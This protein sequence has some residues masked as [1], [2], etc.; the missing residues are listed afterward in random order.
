MPVTFSN[1]NGTTGSFTLTNNNN[2]G[3]LNMSFST[4]RPVPYSYG[5]TQ[6][7]FDFSN[8]GSYSNS[9]T[10]IAD[11][12]GNG[13][14]GIFTFGTGNG[15]ATTVTGYNTNGY[16]TLPGDSTSQLA[17]RLPNALKP[18]TR[19]I[20]TYIVY[21][22][23][24]GYESLSTS[25][26]GIISNDAGGLGLAWGISAV[27][28]GSF[29]TRNDLGFTQVTYSGGAGLNVWSVYAVKYSG[30]VTTLYQYNNNVLYSSSV[31]TAQNVTSNGSFGLYLG[32]RYNNW[33]N[34]DINYVAMYNSALTDAEITAIA[35]Q[36]TIVVPT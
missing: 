2:S 34:A 23:P 31:T 13:N 25:F 24:K 16:L 17:V 36:L 15:T 11:L 21:M 32:L 20:F 26:P 6:L 35:R 9:G 28:T 3:S 8:P 22:R 12:S 30:T 27:Y 1:I 29:T 10:S 7:V 19:A 5:N 33:L 18:T 4:T 14:N